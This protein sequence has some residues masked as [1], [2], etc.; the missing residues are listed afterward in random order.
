MLTVVA[1]IHPKG[2]DLAATASSNVDLWLVIHVLQIPVFGLVALALFLLLRGI[3]GIAASLARIGLALFVTFYTAMDTLA[4]VA[5]G[6]LITR[7]QGLPEEERDIVMDQVGALSADFSVPFAGVGGPAFIITLL[8]GIGW[9]LATVAS[10][11][12]LR[13]T[14][15][16]GGACVLIGLGAIYL[17]HDMPTAPFAV[18]SLLAGITWVELAA[19]RRV[20]DSPHPDPA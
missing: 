10:G 15:A 16:P 20:T 4:G 5:S 17:M 14:G 6:V 8:G 19:R 2:A 3:S 1:T 13:S 9:V 12:A 18:A 7:A 11:V